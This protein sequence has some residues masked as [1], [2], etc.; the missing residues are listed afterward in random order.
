MTTSRPLRWLAAVLPLV[1]IGLSLLSVRPDLHQAFHDHQ[2]HV[3]FH[4]SGDPQ[5]HSHSDSEPHQNETTCTIAMF[6][7]GAVAG[8]APVSLLMLPGPPPCPV[9]ADTGCFLVPDCFYLEP[10]GRAPP[11]FS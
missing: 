7:S 8:A 9:F 2:A 3:G 1:L 5:H 6:A 11:L 4:E 10:P